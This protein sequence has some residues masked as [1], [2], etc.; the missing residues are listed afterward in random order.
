MMT[1]TD[2]RTR[3][4]WRRRRAALCS[5]AAVAV[6]CAVPVALRGQA[7]AA[8][9]LSGR[10]IDA[11]TGDAV[12]GAAV[13]LVPIGL[14]LMPS[15][16]AGAAL[17]DA[18]VHLTGPDGVYRFSELASG[19]YQLRIDR[20]G[21]RP[22]SLQVDIR[23]PIT[24]N[25]SVEL[26]LEPVMLQPVSIDQPAAPLFRRAA[27]DGVGTDSVRVDAE[28]ARQAMFVS[29]DS[30]MLTQADVYDG[31]TLGE[32]DVFRALQ[33]FAGIGTRDDYT[34]ELWT[35][36]A[37]WT[38]TRVT[39]DGLPLFNPVHAAGILSAITPETL[40]AVFLHPGVAP[41]GAATGAAG[42][43][44]LYSRPA[45]G[46]GRL[47]GA[48]DVSMASAKL[49]L[50][51]RLD[52]ASWLLAGRRSHLGMLS[53]N[54]GLI[55]LETVGLP[56]AFHDITA[57]V[58]ARVAA[59][60]TIDA[61]GLWEQDRL[62]GEVAGVLER[63]RARWGNTAARLT[64]RHATA[65]VALSQT[66]GAVRFAVKS[67]ER[68]VRGARPTLSWTEPASSN[69]IEYT[70]VTGVASAT[71]ESAPS[72]SAGYDVA[73]QR[74]RY[75]GPLPRYH[76]V[77]PDTVARVRA[78]RETLVAV[79]WLETRLQPVPGLVIHPGLRLE[80]GSSIANSGPVRAVP[81]VAAR[82]A[83]ADDHSVSAAVGRSWQYLQ[84]VALAGPSVHPAFHAG[85][86]WLGADDDTPA[87][88]ADIVTLGT[89]H[90]LDGGWLLSLGAYARY[91]SG[92]ATADP[93]PGRLGRRPL[94]VT[95][96]NRA[97]GYD[98]TLRRIGAA[99]SGSVAYSF[100]DSRLEADGKRYPS[101][102]DRRHTLDATAGVR[103]LHWL[104]LSAAYTAMTGAPFTRAA[105]RTSGDCATFGFGCGNPQGSYIQEPNA[106]RTPGYRSLDVSL[107][108]SA[109]LAATQVSAYLQLR[110]V[111]GRDNASTY[112]GSVPIG[113]RETREGFDVVWDDR[114][115]QGITRLPLVGV[116]VVF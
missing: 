71:S 18:R 22:A 83:L 61:S 30:R 25:V 96:D 59:G 47:H 56:Y 52:N 2:G 75:D 111:L 70:H 27:A 112:G 26:A 80:S 54:S 17:V 45:S 40:G 38:Q 6:L 53:R 110:N 103:P 109:A 42:L 44:E 69:E 43:V 20:P 78:A 79:L 97:H 3:S 100:G 19:S 14:R 115:E 50:E 49:V 31:V 13:T 63:T 37:P 82:Y 94:F 62:F 58:D 57:R 92:V 4:R 28:R 72:W 36:G 101:P 76:A 7:P 68:E 1:S 90:W 66:I 116:R 88:R 34:A 113:R 21:Y 85:H 55:G 5:S 33:R 35:R 114:F 60:T 32:G 65:R 41:V 46:T 11:G 39:F 106:E 74:G 64:A 77:Q 84:G 108:A 81:R 16:A 91:A 29:P 48:A 51:Q 107:H 99:W 67:V 73:F 89:E 12:D 102:A 23:R 104:R 10:V 8:S 9:T 24:A 93:Q 98:V 86:F 105:T 15:L 95:A 87:V